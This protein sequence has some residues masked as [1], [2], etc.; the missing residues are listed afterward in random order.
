M[1]E[2]AMEEDHT[3]KWEDA[4]VVDHNPRYHQRCTLEA[5]H[6]RTERQKMNQDEGP[7]PLNSISSMVLD[8]DN[9]HFSKYSSN[10]QHGWARISARMHSDF[11]H[12]TA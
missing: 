5:W 3:I 9:L 12:D 11:P 10:F 2:H 7:L 4:E 6:I 1:P 8:T